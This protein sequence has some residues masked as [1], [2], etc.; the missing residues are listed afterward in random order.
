[1]R[2]W[3]RRLFDLGRLVL[4]VALV[5]GLTTPHLQAQQPKEVKVGRIVPLSGLYARP[6]QR[7]L[8][9]ALKWR[10]SASTRKVGLRPLGDG[11]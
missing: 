8:A 10:S 2:S 5:P 7:W 1:M 4:L 9:W 3:R 11:T 6:A